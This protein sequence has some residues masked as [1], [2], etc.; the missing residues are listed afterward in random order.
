M[1]RTNYYRIIATVAVILI[2]TVNALATKH[3]IHASNFVFTPSSITTVTVGDTIEWEWVEGGHTTTSTTIP[4]GAAAW[5]SPLTA[6]NPSFEYKVTVPGTYDYHCT[7]HA[8]L[9][10]TGSFIA[11]PVGIPT[12]ELQ[13]SFLRIFPNPSTGQVNITWNGNLSG[14]EELSVLDI[15]G[16]AIFTEPMPATSEIRLDLTGKNAGIY[17]VKF[18]SGEGIITRKLIL[19]E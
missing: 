15:S 4:S 9:G 10:M 7:P 11:S 6:T 16:K 8:T 2:F 13:N 5:D 18:R 3:I 14:N 17:F 12:T 1:K 19:T